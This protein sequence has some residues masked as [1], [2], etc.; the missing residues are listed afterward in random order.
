MN[1]FFRILLRLK[2]LWYVLGG[3]KLEFYAAAVEGLPV[4]ANLVIHGSIVTDTGAVLDCVTVAAPDYMHGFVVGAR[5]RLSN[6]KAVGM[7]G[8]EIVPVRKGE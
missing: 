7:H 6:C 1:W 5:S 4:A 3:R 8:Y 2:L